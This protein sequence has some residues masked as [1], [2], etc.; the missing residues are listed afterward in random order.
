MAPAFVSPAYRE[1]E[2]P[3]KKEKKKKKN[4]KHLRCTIRGKV[5]K[6]CVSRGGYWVKSNDEASLFFFF[7]HL[8]RLIKARIVN[9]LG[10]SSALL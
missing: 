4:G 7:F 9:S 5:K 1:R 2:R 3:R 10:I 8:P 6:R